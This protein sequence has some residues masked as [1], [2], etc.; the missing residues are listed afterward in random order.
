MYGED[1]SFVCGPKSNLDIAFLPSSRSNALGVL[2]VPLEKAILGEFHVT[3]TL[4][5]TFSYIQQ[6]FT[7]IFVQGPAFDL[8]FLA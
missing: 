7:L 4:A 6:R 2:L 1:Q 5:K 3:C 8:C